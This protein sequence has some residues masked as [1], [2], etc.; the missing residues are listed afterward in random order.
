MTRSTDFQRGMT[1]YS[2]DGMYLGEIKEIWA[3]TASHGHLPISQYLLQDYGPI[4]GSADLLTSTQG[5]L[6]VRQGGI[7]TADRQDIYVPFTEVHTVNARESVTVQLP[8]TH[9]RVLFQELPREFS[10]AA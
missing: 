10:Q 4:K 8:E 5:Y 6:H 7:F 3:E 2:R 1:V 9:C